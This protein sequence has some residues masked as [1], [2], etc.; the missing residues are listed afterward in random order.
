MWLSC[1]AI[2]LLEGQSRLYSPILKKVTE[3]VPELVVVP[4]R[5]TAAQ[6]ARATEHGGHVRQR[7]YWN[8]MTKEGE[9]SYSYV[10]TMDLRFY[11]FF[12]RTS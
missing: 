8:A 11:H 12:P 4:T 10:G 3:L 1:N 9:K 6:V 7:S 5:Y 2:F